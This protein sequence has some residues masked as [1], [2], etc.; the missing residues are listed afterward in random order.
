MTGGERDAAKALSRTLLIYTSTLISQWPQ[1]HT[2]APTRL[3]YP[4]AWAHVP[5]AS[6]SSRIQQ[7]IPA[8]ADVAKAVC[9]TGLGLMQTKPCCPRE[10]VGI[11]KTSCKGISGKRESA[12]RGR[13][14]RRN[15][16]LWKREGRWSLLVQAYCITSIWEASIHQ[17]GTVAPRTWYSMS[18]VCCRL[19]KMLRKSS[20]SY[21]L[22]QFEKIMR[23][24][25]TCC[26]TAGRKLCCCS[27]LPCRK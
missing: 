24:A 19:R 12:A 14:L 9:G 25:G 11:S 23:S 26:D 8:H 16:M 3:K 5:A 17:T 21:F 4:P 1:R 10:R 2:R 7:S 20:Q 6:G 27:F 22:H 15:H 18:D 13:L